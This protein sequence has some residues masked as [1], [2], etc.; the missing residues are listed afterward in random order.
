MPYDYYDSNGYLAPGPTVPQW[1]RLR[2]QLTGTE[3]QQLA[4]TGRTDRPLALA[5]EL[6]GDDPPLRQLKAAAD[7]ADTS[8]LISDGTTEGTA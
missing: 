4:E 7:R 2:E 8:L 5:D 6:E 1:Q 3:G